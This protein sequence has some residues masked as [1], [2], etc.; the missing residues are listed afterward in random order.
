MSWQST[1]GPGCRL[2]IDPAGIFLNGFRGPDALPGLIL[3]R[4]WGFLAV[5]AV[6]DGSPADTAGL[7]VGDL[8]VAVDGQPQDEQRL[9][10]LLKNLRSGP[11]LALRVRR[12]QGVLD[13]TFL[14]PGG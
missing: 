10:E 5:T 4:A 9:E 1:L 12:G 3:G 6:E 11:P 8:I 2:E 13:L 14:P 7:R